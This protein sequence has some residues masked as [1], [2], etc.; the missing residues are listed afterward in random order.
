LSEMFL[1]MK[2][3]QQQQQQP[4]ASWSTVVSMEYTVLQR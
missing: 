1:A 4:A 3:Q 2:L